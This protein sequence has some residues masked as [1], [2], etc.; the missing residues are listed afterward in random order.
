MRSAVILAGGSGRRLGSEKAL[1]K[2]DGRPLLGWIVEKLQGVADE[3][4][5]V[6]RSA[7]HAQVL[8][9]LVPEALL[10]WDRVGDYGP[11]AGL[12]A[13]MRCAKGDF[14]FATGCDLPFLS[15]EVVERLFDLLDEE[16]GYGGAVPVRPNGFYEPLHSVYH[17]ERMCSACCRALE[18]EERRIHVPLQELHILCVPVESLRPLD[19]ELLTFFNLN[20]PGDL[21]EAK[22]IWSRPQSQ[23][24]CFKTR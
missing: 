13:G 23:R 16:E 11:V 14:A 12:E 17:R 3:V 5:V 2:F 7:D 15:P 18:R 24:V 19:P 6:A 9:E 10:A 8:E 4:V 1:F 22:K 20:T 21:D